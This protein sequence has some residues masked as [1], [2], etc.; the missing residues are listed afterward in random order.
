MISINEYKDLKIGNEFIVKFKFIPG[1]DIV[2]QE[3]ICKITD[4]KTN[5][6]PYKTI[7]IFYSCGYIDGRFQLKSLVS[8]SCYMYFRHSNLNTLNI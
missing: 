7:D 8:D 3:S 1:N 6:Y 5:E 4:I 2:P